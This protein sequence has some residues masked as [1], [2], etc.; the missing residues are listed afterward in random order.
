MKMKTLKTAILMVIMAAFTAVVSCE[1]NDDST[2]N[3]TFGKGVFITNEG[4]FQTGTGTIT[5][6]DSDSNLVKQ[7]I[8]EKVNG[9]PLGNV[10]QSMTIL[11]GKAYIVVNN[12]AKIEV[13]DALTF[14]SEAVITSSQSIGLPRYL[15]GINETKAYVS[16]WS[17]FVAVVDLPSNK[18]TQTIQ[19][20]KGPEVMLK[21][22]NYVYVA[23]CGAFGID[24]SIT[25]IDFSTDKVVKTIKVGDVPSG[26]VA[27][28]YGRIWVLCKGKGYA[29]WPAA[30]D[31]R[32][33]LT[34]INPATLEVDQTFLFWVTTDHPE[35][36]VINKQKSMLFCLYNNGIYYFDLTQQYPVPELLVSSRYFYALGYED[37]TGYLYAADAGDFSENGVV[38]RYKADNGELVDS[39]Q[40]G[41]IPGGFVFTE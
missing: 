22:G 3:S 35:K 4:K 36:L 15:L 21:S 40:A 7:N 23:N 24:N 38:L 9:R 32:G 26:M 25:V 19:T 8:F 31:T 1:R 6:F 28:A 30:D 12:A 10:V 5:F 17:G 39:I 18:V 13:V 11:N 27:D 33:C 16:D 2:G 20:G 14:K 29:P 41:V 34:R 37:K